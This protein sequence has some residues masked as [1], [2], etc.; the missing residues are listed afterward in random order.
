MLKAKCFTTNGKQL[1][2][3]KHKTEN[4]L[5]SYDSHFYSRKD[6]ENIK[7]ILSSILR[8]NSP[9]VLTKLPQMRNAPK[10][11]SNEERLRAQNECH[12]LCKLKPV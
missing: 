2:R 12:S 5:P 4:T 7:K 6:R 9:K 3:T 8:V 11:V 1:T 10:S